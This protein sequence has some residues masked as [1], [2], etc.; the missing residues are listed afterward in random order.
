MI[1]F[2]DPDLHVPLEAASALSISWCRRNKLEAIIGMGELQLGS[3]HEGQ[4]ESTSLFPSQQSSCLV[5][6]KGALN[7]ACKNLRVQILPLAYDRFLGKN[8]P[9]WWITKNVRNLLI[10]WFLI[11]VWKQHLLYGG[12][13]FSRNFKFYHYASVVI[14]YNYMT[15]VYCI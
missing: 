11:S 6:I 3:D 12:Y 4:S 1:N 13:A 9:N 15:F 8:T 5:L 14:V 10:L 7:Y 2:T